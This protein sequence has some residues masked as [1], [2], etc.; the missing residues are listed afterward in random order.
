MYNLG[1]TIRPFDQL[2]HSYKVVSRYYCQ[3]ENSQATWLLH[4]QDTLPVFDYCLINVDTAI[5]THLIITH[6]DD[7]G[8]IPREQAVHNII[9][10]D[11]LM[12]I[13]LVCCHPGKVRQYYP[14]WRGFI[15]GKWNDETLVMLKDG[16]LYICSEVV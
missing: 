12:P 4:S 9:S 2:G 3:S 1:D 13:T 16:I 11:A 6:S 5:L 10:S 15:L 7:D 14:F 8:I